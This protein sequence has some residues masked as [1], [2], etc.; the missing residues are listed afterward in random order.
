MDI[1]D[2][3]LIGR[4]AS[5]K[6]QPVAGNAVSVGKVTAYTFAALPTGQPAGSVAFCTNGRA[7]TGAVGGGG[8]SMTL[9]GSGAGTGVLVTYNGTAW[10]IAG[11]N[12]TV[13]AT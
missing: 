11:T 2:L 13:S 8:T 4:T 10:K 9:E 12:V 1:S 5:P 6:L 7:F 3:T